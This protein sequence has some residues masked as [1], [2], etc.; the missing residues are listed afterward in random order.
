[1][2][3]KPFYTPDTIRPPAYQLRYN[4]T[5]WPSNSYFPDEP[6]EKFFDELAE[7]CEADGI[8]LLERTWSRSRILLTTS[9]KPTVSPTLFTTRMKG[10]LQHAL[11]EKLWPLDFSR[12]VSM[13]SVGDADRSTT[14]RYV[15]SQVDKEPLA[16]PGSKPFLERFTVE[17]EDVDLSKPVATRRGRYWYNLHL[18]FVVRD[19]CRIRKPHRLRVIRDGAMRV[20][21]AKD[22]RMSVF[23]AVPDHVHMALGGAVD[24]SPEEIALAYMNNLA[25][26]AGHALWEDSYYAGTF[27]EYDMN[28]VRAGVARQSDSPTG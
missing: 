13:N 14:E 15:A 2:S 25:Y 7:R 21:R 8:R 18:V 28:A 27:G 16:D 19:R 26:F 11:R 10:R 5:G 23:S 3:P 17:D 24:Q 22:H 9:V 6:N 12:K 1:M 20:A 4:W